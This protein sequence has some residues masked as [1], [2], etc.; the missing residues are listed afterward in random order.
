MPN[1]D[2]FN[3]ALD[4]ASPLDITQD[5]EVANPSFERPDPVK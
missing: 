2:P 1:E 5:R 4:T 3:Q